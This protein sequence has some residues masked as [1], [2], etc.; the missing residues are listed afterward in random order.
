MATP[1]IATAQAARAR[2]ESIRNRYEGFH[3]EIEFLKTLT[4]YEAEID[5][6]LRQADINEEFTFRGG[7][8]VLTK[9][10]QLLDYREQTGRQGFLF[11]DTWYSPSELAQE[12]RRCI[13]KARFTTQSA[14]ISASF[15]VRNVQKSQYV[16]PDTLCKLEQALKD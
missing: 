15:V 13:I 5:S 12:L 2:I 7:D 10:K 11:R 1:R 9:A 3:P 4:Y 14:Q 16:A 6:F 8:A